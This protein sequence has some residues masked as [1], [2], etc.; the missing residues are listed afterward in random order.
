MENVLIIGCSHSQGSYRT[1]TQTDNVKEWEIA[2]GEICP[3]HD[4]G[5]W[6]FVD[7]LQ[8][9]DVSILSMPGG[10]YMSFYEVLYMLNQ[11]NKLSNFDTIIIQETDEPRVTFIED[12]A[13]SKWGRDFHVGKHRGARINGGRMK[14]YLWGVVTGGKWHVGFNFL[15][16]HPAHQSKEDLNKHQDLLGDDTIR[17]YLSNAYTSQAFSELPLIFAEKIA[18]ICKINNIKIYV[19]R[20]SNWF[21][22]NIHLKKISN[23]SDYPIHNLMEVD[24]WHLPNIRTNNQA[25]HSTVEGNKN[26]GKMINSAIMHYE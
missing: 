13:I 6:S 12:K 16:Y 18:R 9:C 10:G 3:R 26:I 4:I 7:L 21:K 24:V 8:S 19:W 5:W 25:G 22:E 14:L 20:W 2:R 17:K 11:E 1:I 15:S 23:Y